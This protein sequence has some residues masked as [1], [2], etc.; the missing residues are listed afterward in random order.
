[1]PRKL[2]D[3]VVT[4]LRDGNAVLIEGAY[5][6]PE[7]GWVAAVKRGPENEMF[8]GLRTR[9]TSFTSFCNSSLTFNPFLEKMIAARNEA[10]DAAL[11][12]IA[13]ERGESLYE[14]S[15]TPW[16]K[17]RGGKSS[18]AALPKLS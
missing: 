1:M 14:G 12:D 9:K 16:A 4:P 2:R 6:L 13:H 11:K 5:L 15:N 18:L 17:I 3:V 7:H 10:S 8:I